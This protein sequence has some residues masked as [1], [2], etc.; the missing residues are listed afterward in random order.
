M[1]KPEAPK[2][3]TGKLFV[4]KMILNIDE[5]V[6]KGGVNGC[7]CQH[8]FQPCVVL[9]ITSSGRCVRLF[10]AC[11]RTPPKSF[12]IQAFVNTRLD[13]CN[14][15]YFGKAVGLM[16]RLQ[17]VQYAAARLITG[18]TSYQ[19][20]VS[21]AGCRYADEWISRYPPFSIGRWLAPLL[22]T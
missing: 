10:D 18:V 19:P 9:A 11:L 17:S 3:L 8:R 2:G 4:I 14:S 12:L 13:Y 5:P 20:Y 16:S 15:L 7:R 21:C 1:L 22:C 6:E